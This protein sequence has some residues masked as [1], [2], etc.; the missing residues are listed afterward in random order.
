MGAQ[1]KGIVLPSARMHSASAILKK[2]PPVSSVPATDLARPGQNSNLI[3]FPS[4]A[5][6][7][8]TNNNH[9][10]NSRKI[11][12]ENINKNENESKNKSKSRSEREEQEQQEE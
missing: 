10:K 1:G 5:N 4:N 8:K 6:E 9:K 7:S 2:N 3:K 12:N 11:K